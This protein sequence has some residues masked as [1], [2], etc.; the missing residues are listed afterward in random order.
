MTN[1]IRPGDVYKYNC[2]NNQGYGYMIPVRTSAGWDFIDTYHLDFPPIRDDE[3]K[4]RASIRQ[5][6]ELGHGEHDGYVSRVTAEFYYE[7]AYFKR[8]EV[9]NGLRLLLNLCDY[10]V[11][12]RRECSDYV[13]NDVLYDVPLYHG[14]H[15]DWSSGRT[16][17]LCFVRKGA[18]KSTAH[19][20]RSLISDAYESLVYPCTG[21]AVTKLGEAKKKLCELEESGLSTQK[22]ADDVFLLAKYIE[23]I[24][25]C[26][27]KLEEID[28]KYK[29]RCRDSN[30]KDSE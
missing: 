20:F 5:V 4:D 17:G 24:R 30:G 1:N 19:E 6:I 26:I 21:V 18:K 10:D 23:A 2:E 13:A 25:E 12:S 28:R 27:E 9:P 15:F 14:Q 29:E 3:T 8:T 11:A 7:N 22:D 16:L